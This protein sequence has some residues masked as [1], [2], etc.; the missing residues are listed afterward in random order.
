M[1]EEK[2]E[3]ICES[4]MRFGLGQSNFDQICQE[5]WLTGIVG[6]K[7]LK[8]P[9]KPP[10]NAGNVAREDMRIILQLSTGNTGY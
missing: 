6:V 1:L 5:S 4:M 9:P 2:F 8:R 10:K 3:S 7:G